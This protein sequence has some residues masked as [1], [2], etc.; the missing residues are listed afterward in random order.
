MADIWDAYIHSHIHLIFPHRILDSNSQH[1]CDKFTMFHA[2]FPLT[3]GFLYV[4]NLLRGLV[5]GV[6]GFRTL[7]E[8]TTHLMPTLC[9]PHPA[10]LLDAPI[11]PLVTISSELIVIEVPPLLQP[12]PIPT[13]SYQSSLVT[14]SQ[15]RF[16]DPVHILLMLAFISAL[17]F[18]LP[19]LIYVFANIASRI[20]ALSRLSRKNFKAS[21]FNF[22]FSLVPVFSFVPLCNL[23]PL[24]SLVPN[25]FST[26]IF[27]LRLL[28]SLFSLL[29]LWTGPPA[30]ASFVTL[31]FI[32][33]KLSTDQKFSNMI[34]KTLQRCGLLT[35]PDTETPP[36]LTT[37]YEQIVNKTV[38][39]NKLIWYR[40]P[41]PEPKL[42]QTST[43]TGIGTTISHLEILYREQEL[44][45]SL[46]QH[47]LELEQEK[48]NTLRT[49]Y[50]YSALTDSHNC[51]RRQLDISRS[52]EGKLQIDLL[53]AERERKKLKDIIATLEAS[54]FALRADLA[55]TA[56]ETREAAIMF[57]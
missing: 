51:L 43:F 5:R 15:H 12:S 31:I 14:V 1:H 13:L 7:R 45:N 26:R 4:G 46:A 10:H 29:L 19:G 33:F 39:N 32:L 48:K 9:S 18:F 55:A 2:L 47:K 21:S 36:V 42:D 57:D 27:S 50:I 52:R 24:F 40:S 30:I 16:L 23:V 28:V 37:I 25:F 49:Q 22:G 6:L 54:D 44:L 34:V 38:T 41:P 56:D 35:L 8:M 3:S 17:V 11:A 53:T 20:S